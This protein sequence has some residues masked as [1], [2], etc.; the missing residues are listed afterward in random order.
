MFELKWNVDIKKD[1][2]PFSSCAIDYANLDYASLVLIE[3][4]LIAALNAL[5]EEGQKRVASK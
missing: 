4:K 2:Q 1:G 5:H 3:G